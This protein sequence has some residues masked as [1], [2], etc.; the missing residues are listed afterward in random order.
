MTQYHLGGKKKPLNE[1]DPRTLTTL[2]I[3]TLVGLA[4]WWWILF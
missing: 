4:F 1:I 2:T 3:S